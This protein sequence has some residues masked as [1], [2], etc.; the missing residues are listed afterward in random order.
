M[1]PSLLE[2]AQNYFLGSTVR[3][4]STAFG[5]PEDRLN[6]A[7]RSVV[8]LA[9][10]GLLARA[11]A[12]GGV[13]ELTEWAQ[14]VH[15]RGLLSDLSGLLSG[16]G[17]S[18]TTATPTADSLPNRGAD[19]LQSLLGAAYL[20][21]VAGISQQAGI[22]APTV[23]N[24]LSVAVAAGLGLLGRHIAQHNLPVD[25]LRNYLGSQ[26]DDILGALATLPGGWGQSVAKLITDAPAAKVEA[27]T[28]IPPPSLA[29]P[30]AT[31][32]TEVAPRIDLAAAAISTPATTINTP[33]AA[34]NTPVAAVGTPA[35]A[36][37]TPVAAINT[38]AATIS[39]PA[40]AAQPVV[41]AVPPRPAV[42]AAVPVPAPAVPRRWPWLVVLALALVLAVLGY[43]SRRPQ[44]A[45]S[46]PVTTP[47]ATTQVAAPATRVVAPTGH[48]EAATGHYEAAT[49]TYQYDAGASTT[50]SLPTGTTLTVGSHSAE[51][52]LWQLLT[53]STQSL[54]ADKTRSGI[55]L[56]Q[57]YFNAG[58]ATLT[59][60]S[61]TQL[62]NLAALL[63][64]FPRA[65]LKFGGFT[66]DQGSAEANLLLS[67]DRANTVRSTLV[68]TGVAPTRVAAQGYGQAHP[69]ASNATPAG[70]AQNRR[71]AALLIKK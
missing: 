37:S 38:P 41:R 49:D 17:A 21:A 68:A 67:A 12:P 71:V 66:D 5:E 9:L 24:L 29:S 34:I 51:A 3:Q 11:Q 32:A 56:D 8:P 22:R 39:T 62:T 40:A 59:T 52:Q 7:L 69:V 45:A 50:L 10:G 36:I 53:D 44:L 26:R 46:E 65:T 6:A 23:S 2:L 48:Y 33:A 1:N 42:R 63:A 61:Q 13:T 18:P 55:V 58:Q 14:Q 57:V 70:Q 15:K 28:P 16:L 4:V 54:T 35:A 25:G 27:A 19:M 60:A 20:P 47:A 64:A 30:V 31:S 43:L